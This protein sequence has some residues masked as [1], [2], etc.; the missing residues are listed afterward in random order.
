MESRNANRNLNVQ[1]IFFA[2]FRDKDVGIG[3]CLPKILRHIIHLVQRAP[4]LAPFAPADVSQVTENSEIISTVKPDFSR[5]GMC[6]ETSFDLKPGAV[7]QV[8][9]PYD[10]FRSRARVAAVRPSK[11]HPERSL[12]GL[13]FLQSN[14]D[15]IIH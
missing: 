1:S 12:I 2:A 5:E 9:A 7:L 15:W 10:G 6:V 4:R 11:S 8:C 14:K 3:E 13:K